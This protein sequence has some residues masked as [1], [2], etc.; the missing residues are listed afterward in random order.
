[1]K[2]ND[3]LLSCYFEKDGDQWLG[4]CLDFSLVAQADTLNQAAE[5]LEAQMLEYVQDATVGEDRQHAQYLLRRRA[6]L[7][8]WA[9]FYV[10]LFRQRARHKVQASKRRKAV[11][12]PMPMAPIHCHA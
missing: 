4:F 7:R 12:E 1:M 3:L 9:K 2:T 8:Y 10:T 5:K 6:P 11:V